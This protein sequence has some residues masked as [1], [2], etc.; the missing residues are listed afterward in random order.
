MKK[1]GKQA[2][3]RPADYYGI[4]GFF[5][6]EFFDIILTYCTDIVKSRLRMLGLENDREV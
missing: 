4:G 5:I 3:N 6:V 2:K 1:Y